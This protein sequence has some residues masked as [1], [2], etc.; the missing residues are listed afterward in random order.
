MKKLILAMAVLAISTPA[1]ADD[2]LIAAGEKGFKTCGTCHRIESPDGLVGKWKAKT[3][4]NLYGV[5]G[6]T[7]G[8]LDTFARGNGKTKFGKDIVAAGEA[9][10]V[11]NDP[12]AFAAYVKNPKGFLGEKLGKK[13]KSKMAAQ[14]K[15][16][17]AAIY[18]FLE[19]VAK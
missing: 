16:D 19:S 6:R 2:E 7:A 15:A 18:A 14:K 1:L 10:L 13:A 4:P 17:G 11:W 12:E 5:V 9:G 3:G 8:T